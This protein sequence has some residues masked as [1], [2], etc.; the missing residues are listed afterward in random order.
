MA[1]IK[2]PKCGREISSFAENCNYCGHPISSGQQEHSASDGQW[3]SQT[4]SGGA[5]QYQEKGLKSGG[6]KIAAFFIAI[7]VFAGAK[8]LGQIAGAAMHTSQQPQTVRENA[9]VNTDTAADTDADADDTYTDMDDT[10]TDITVPDLED[11]LVLQE[12][13]LAYSSEG[14]GEQYETVFYKSG[15]YIVNELLYET[16]ILKDAVSDFIDP[17]NYSLSDFEDFY[18][19][20][21][22]SS[23]SVQDI[24]NY[25]LLTV[26]YTGLDDADTVAA[27]VS[28]GYLEWKDDGEHEGSLMNA[29]FYMNSLEE[30]GY[31]KGNFADKEYASYFGSGRAENQ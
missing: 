22:A 14:V 16:F 25:Y 29:T 10:N 2:C 27:L 9:V 3:N 30:S 1:V 23:V 31:E 20:Y 21:G 12:R 28:A 13:Y 8:I 7:A 6:K 24:G 19:D 26:D 4:G 11:V 17:E 5:D 18:T 15:S